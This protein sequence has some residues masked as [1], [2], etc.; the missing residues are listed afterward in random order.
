VS[1]SAISAAPGDPVTNTSG[2]VAGGPPRRLFLGAGAAALGIAAAACS[3]TRAAR[4]PRAGLQLTLFPPAGPYRVGTVPLHLV[5]RSRPDPWVPARARELMVSVWYPALDAARYPRAPWMPEAAGDLFLEQLIP[6][7]AVAT[8]SRINRR[9][10]PAPLPVSLHGV[11]LPLTRARQGAPVDLPGQ[12]SPVVLC[13]PGFGD[14]RALGTGLVSDLA[15]RGYAVVTMDDTYEAAEVEFPDGR[16]AVPRRP[17][18]Y[19]DATRIADTRFVLDELAA[20]ESGVNPDAEQRPLPAG[21]TQAL[22]LTQIGMF[23]HSLGGATAAKAMAA[24]ARIGA[25][26]DLD[27]SLFL[28]NPSLHLDPEKAGAAVGRQIGDRPFMIMSSH[29]FGPRD[30]PSWRGFWPSLRGWRLFLTMTNA[31][32]YT[33]TDLEEFLSQL[34]AAEIIPPRLAGRLV[35]PVIG[36]V[37]PARAVAAERA[38]ISA[39][40]DLH[41]RGRASKLLDHASSSFPDIQFL[42][43]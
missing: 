37:N 34:L 19:A 32:H 2:V 17:S 20:L 21:L 27:G 25:G 4:K 30:D 23:G 41:L 40:F 28:T 14:V 33:Y 12:R 18:A 39:F 11:R 15:S 43:R 7:H 26:I 1:R 13:Q 8:G 24:D 31:Q 6:S 9:R 36:T 3:T 22:D 38:Y 35:A 29:G 42:G 16:V 10:T 5:D